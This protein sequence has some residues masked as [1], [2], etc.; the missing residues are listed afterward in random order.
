MLISWS[1][2]GTYLKKTTTVC[3]IILNDILEIMFNNAVFGCVKTMTLAHS[4]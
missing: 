3:V 1:V 4:K 2:F